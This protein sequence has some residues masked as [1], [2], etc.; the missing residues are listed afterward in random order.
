MSVVSQVI[1]SGEHLVFMKGAPEMVIKFC[2]AE[3]GI[4]NKV[5]GALEHSL[6][7]GAKSILQHTLPGPN[8]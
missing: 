1:G 6:P 2:C 8:I 5:S 3:S 4:W 7:Q